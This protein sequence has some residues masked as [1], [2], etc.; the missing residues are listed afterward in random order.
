[1]ISDYVEHDLLEDVLEASVQTVIDVE[2]FWRRTPMGD[3]ERPPRIH[4]YILNSLRVPVLKLGA[5]MRSAF[6]QTHSEART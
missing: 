4:I 2:E 5:A 6:H 1:M 3:V